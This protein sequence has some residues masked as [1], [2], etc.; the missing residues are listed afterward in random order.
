[1]GHN[2]YTYAVADG[3]PNYSHGVSHYDTFEAEIFDRLKWHRGAGFQINDR[4]KDKLPESL[5]ELHLLLDNQPP[6]TV[7]KI[8]SV[9]DGYDLDAK[10]TVVDT[11]KGDMIIQ[12]ARDIIGSPYVWDAAGPSAFDCSGETL[13]IHKPEGIVLPHNAAAQHSLFLNHAPGFFPIT[14]AQVKVGDLVFFD[15]DHHV[16]PYAGKLPQYGN[17]ECVIDAEPDDTGA[18]AGWPTPNLQTGI[19]VRPMIG[20]YY[21]SWINS[22]GAGRIEAINGKP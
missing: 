9:K 15:N 13:W 18:P 16:A 2:R 5:K 21:C 4:T 14:R 11:S 7:F 19:R 22:S 10:R 3:S 8:K 1:M 20:N 12:N 17:I 6:G